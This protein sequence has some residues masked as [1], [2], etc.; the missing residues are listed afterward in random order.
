MLKIRKVILYW[1]PVLIWMSLIYFLSSF[2]NLQASVIAWQ[3]FVIRKTVHFFEYAVLFVLLNR[4][5]LSTTKIVFRKRIWL[6][7][8]LALFYASTDEYHQTFV[9]GRSGR[10]RDFLIDGLGVLAGLL[11]VLKLIYRLPEKV[12]KF[13]TS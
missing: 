3:D 2:H 1:L 11:F 5:T 12:Q 13:L 7:L 8:L 6:V 9:A 10:I 4:A